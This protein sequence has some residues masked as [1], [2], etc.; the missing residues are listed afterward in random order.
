MADIKNETMRS[1][2]LA[3]ER[4]SGLTSNRI[5]K[6]KLQVHSKLSLEAVVAHVDGNMD[7]G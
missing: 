4:Q 1:S 2:Q 5:M 3:D 6:N 7:A